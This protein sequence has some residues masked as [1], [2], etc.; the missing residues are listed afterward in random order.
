MQRWYPCKIVLGGE[1]S[2][3]GTFAHGEAS[4]GIKIAKSPLKKTPHKTIKDVCRLCQ[5]P[6]SAC[7]LLA[8]RLLLLLFHIATGTLKR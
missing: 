8:R 2:F 4:P 1:T 6:F 7:R 3:G 5:L